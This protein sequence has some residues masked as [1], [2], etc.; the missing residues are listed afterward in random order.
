MAS[1][2][3]VAAVGELS[4]LSASGVGAPGLQKRKRQAVYA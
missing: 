4:L 2:K 1:E 3:A